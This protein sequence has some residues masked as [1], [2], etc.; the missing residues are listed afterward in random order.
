MPPSGRLPVN[1]SPIA[2]IAHNQMKGIYEMPI[3]L[4]K[5]EVIMRPHIFVTAEKIGDLRSVNEVREGIRFGHAK[6]LWETIRDQANA[7]CG[8]DPLTLTS[9]IPGGTPSRFATPTP[10]GPSSTPRGSACRWLPSPPLSAV[11][12]SIATA[13]CVRWKSFSTAASGPNGVTKPTLTTKPTCVPGCWRK[14]FR[15]PTIGSIPISPPSNA[16]GS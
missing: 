10:T 6:V 16:D 11:I 4:S 7:D 9:E 13:H 3:K 12:S 15:W 14:I 8:A 1:E 2:W 5:E